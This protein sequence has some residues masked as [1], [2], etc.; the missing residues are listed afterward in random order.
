MSNLHD[1]FEA[2]D[3]AKQQSKTALWIVDDILTT[4]S[5]ALSA[6]TTLQQAGYKVRGLI[7]LARTPQKFSG[8]PRTL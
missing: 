7:C 8:V 6:R 3:A 1:A 4:G 2:V 5:T